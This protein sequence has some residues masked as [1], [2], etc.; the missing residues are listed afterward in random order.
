MSS[1]YYNSLVSVLNDAKVAHE[2]RLRIEAECAASIA[3]IK[4]YRLEM[5]LVINN[6]LRENI[7]VFSVAFAEMELAYNTGDV[8]SFICGANSIIRQLGG[9]PIFETQEEFSKLMNS[10]ITFEL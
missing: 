10:N 7:K 8:D 3:A 1:A 4:E 5:E 9:E 6:Y 2:E